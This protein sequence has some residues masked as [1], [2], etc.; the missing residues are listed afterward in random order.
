MRRLLSMLLSLYLILFLNLSMQAVVS[1]LYGSH[2]FSS[3][4]GSHEQDAR[5][6]SRPYM[7]FPELFK[8]AD[9]VH[10]SIKDLIE[11]I[12][13]IK[14]AGTEAKMRKEPVE[15]VVPRIPRSRLDWRKMQMRKSKL[16]H[17]IH[18]GTHTSLFLLKR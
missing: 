9:P 2:P 10:F 1:V 7:R 14:L 6:T 15:K 18:L 5:A 11:P 4:H 12:R 17:E 13:M 3:R 16:S 8:T